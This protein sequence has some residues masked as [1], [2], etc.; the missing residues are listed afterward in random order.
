MP[1]LNR[2]NAPVITDAV[3]F[4]LDLPAHE[5]I[6]LRNGV[7]VFLVNM[8]TLDTLMMNVVFYWKSL[9]NRLALGKLFLMHLIRIRYH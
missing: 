7:D 4:H 2:K 5:K 9:I 1:I 6:S 3:K 8:G